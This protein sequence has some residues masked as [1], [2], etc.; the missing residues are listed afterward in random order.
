MEEVTIQGSP[1]V[2]VDYDPVW[3]EQFEALRSRI[4]QLLGECVAAIEHVGSTSVRALAAKPVIDLD[5][6]LRSGDDLLRSSQ[7]WLSLDISIAAI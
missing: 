3:P 6:L 5:V 7:N 1:A 4:A 2:I